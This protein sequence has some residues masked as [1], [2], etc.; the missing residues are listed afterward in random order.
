MPAPRP[1]SPA[2][3]DTFGQTRDRS[4]PAAGRPT[5]RRR[6]E[7]PISDRHRRPPSSPAMPVTS[8]SHQKAAMLNLIAAIR[9][10]PGMT[11]RAFLRYVHDVHG[12]LAAANPLRI[13][14]Y[15]QNHV[16]DS[17]FG[18][19]EDPA[20]VTDF[21]RDNV[22]EPHSRP[23][24]G[25]GQGAALPARA[26][27]AGPRHL[28]RAMAF[29]AR[30]GTLAGGA[31]YQ[32]T[33]RLRPAPPGTRRRADTAPLRALTHFPRYERALREAG[34]ACFYDRSHAFAL[35][36]REVTVFCHPR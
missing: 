9:R 23:G 22:T 2:T 31:S 5:V 4:A 26:G 27:R 8:S 17:S 19:A 21:G 13:R 28:H 32:G 11:H 25:P 12:S 3:D 24:H 30:G 7:N 10:K 18:S 34:A 15:L 20:Y 1:P 16:F 29:R 14:D 36:T 33:A 6:H 35:Y